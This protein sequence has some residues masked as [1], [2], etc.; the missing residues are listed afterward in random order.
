LRRL[1][2]AVCINGFALAFFGL[3]QFFSSPPQT[4]F[5]IFPVGNR[6][7]GPFINRDHFAFYINLCIGLSGGLW[8]SLLP[9][10]ERQPPVLGLLD[11][12]LRP[13]E[14]LNTPA[15]LWV[16]VGLI[17]MLG[18]LVLSLSRGAILSLIAALAIFCAARIIRARRVEVPDAGLVLGILVL[19]VI[20]WFG[21]NSVMA[22][23][24]TIWKGDPLEDQRLPA[25]FDGLRIAKE[26]PLLGSGFGSFLDVDIMYRQRAIGPHSGWENAHNDYLEALVE[27]GIV[28]LG[29]S[30][31]VIFLVYRQGIRALRRLEGRSSRGLVIGALFGFTTI[32]LHSFVDFGLHVQAIAVLATVV[33][34]H[35]CAQGAGGEVRSAKG[36]GAESS[37]LP[38]RVIRLGGLAPLTGVV[39]AVAVSWVL[40]AQGWR[41]AQAYGSE[42]AARGPASLGTPAGEELRRDLLDAATKACPEDAHLHLLAGQAYVDAYQL[43]LGAI[44]QRAA[45]GAALGPAPI[46]HIAETHAAERAELVRTYLIPALRHY[47]VARDLCPLMAK[48]HIRIA[49]DVEQFVNADLREDYLRRAEMAYPRSSEVWYLAG[50]LELKD[51]KQVKAWDSWRRSLELGTE[52]LEPILDRAKQL[53]D[54]SALIAAVLPDQPETIWAASNYLYPT[55]NDK[56]RRPFLQRILAVL[57]DQAK[58]PTA[59]EFH[60]RAK[61]EA[62]LGDDLKRAIKDYEAALHLE[63]DQYEWRYEYA[64][65]L[66]RDG[67]RDDARR[68]LTTVKARIP[69]H[70]QAA[71]LLEQIANEDAIGPQPPP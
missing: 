23:L 58:T 64:A 17:F 59:E 50:L 46:L 32:V 7:F 36:R 55:V 40:C 16:S 43:R 44:E 29:L 35:L 70:V 30:L 48:P 56:K 67:R 2:T 53:L 3:I 26:F 45:L 27:G 4:L 49:A 12:L 13:L 68:Q 31:L 1:A 61:A 15:A 52:Y 25:W 69:G 51:D 34:A 19:A 33:A 28:R 21:L 47:L 71:Q 24:A 54:T 8:L 57:N 66:Y 11:W 65:V 6:P 9:K 10:K 42:V 41:W 60:W 39:T 38:P 5:W 37:Q 14:I 62:E 22:H 63:P 18:G 20:A